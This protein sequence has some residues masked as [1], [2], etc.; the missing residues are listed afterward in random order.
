MNKIE[1]VAEIGS[2][3]YAPGGNGLERAKRLIESA[4]HN[5]AQVAKFQMFKA[6]EL[7]RDTKKQVG[8]KHLELP[9]AWIPELHKTCNDNGVEF[10]CTPFYLDAVDYLVEYVNR[11]KVASWDCTYIP[12]LEKIASFGMPTVLSTGSAEMEEIDTA[13]DILSQE[14]ELDQITVL[15]CTGG[16]PT[17]PADMNL[18]R[19]VTIAAEFF[20][21]QVGLSSHCTIPA[22]TASSVLLGATMIEVHYDLKDRSGAE[23]GHSYTPENFSDMTRMAKMF[24]DAKSCGCEVTLTDT[25]ARNMYYR[26]PSD[27]LRGLKTVK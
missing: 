24:M 22:I 14:T 26:D 1:F 27:W 21:V 16:Y 5:G 9:V 25:V 12:L 19:I 11:W 13:L 3:W 17:V 15:H 18:D 23:A 8:L 2:N 4:A 20:P 6:D 7:Y 10:A